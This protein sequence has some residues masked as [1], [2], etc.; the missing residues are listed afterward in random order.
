MVGTP[1]R[2][3]RCR[4]G[5]APRRPLP[6][7]MSASPTP[8]PVPK[9]SEPLDIPSAHAVSRSP[10]AAASPV[11]W[12]ASSPGGV[13][14][15]ALMS[16]RPHS[17]S[18]AMSAPMR[19]TMASGAQFTTPARHL[20]LSR[21]RSHHMHTASLPR[22]SVQAEPGLLASSA[23]STATMS[24]VSPPS[25]PQSAGM[26]GM[27][28]YSE[29]LDTTDADG[30]WPALLQVGVDEKLPAGPTE[31]LGRPAPR[32]AWPPHPRRVPSPT[33]ERIILDHLAP[34]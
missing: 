19:D 23:T 27:R 20:S 29:R 21:P 9:K 30:A 8:I 2:P 1:S 26:G 12:H 6:T 25:T 13:S 15:H 32:R 34:L 14:Q 11:A 28:R 24:D 33:S 4:A 18:G 17:L 16:A 7:T 31:N 5:R 3:R 10:L 22:V